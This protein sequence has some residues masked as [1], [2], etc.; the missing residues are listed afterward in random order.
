MRNLTQTAA[1]L[2][3]GLMAG[4]SGAH[5]SSPSGGDLPDAS[6][7]TGN[8]WNRDGGTGTG[9]AT[10]T[11][12]GSGTGTG[13]AD[14]G[15]TAKK[16]FLADCAA[17][18]ECESK[19]CLASKRCSK[20]CADA[21]EC[22]NGGWVCTPRGQ[23]DRVCLCAP[24]SVEDTCDGRDND[25]D[26]EVD[27]GASCEG[28]AVC[29]AGS[30]SCPAANTC[31]TDCADLTKDPVHCGTCTTVCGMNEACENGACKCNGKVCDG[32]CTETAF[33]SS[34]CG[35]CAT[36]CAA[37]QECINSACV[38]VDYDWASW[39]PAAGPN[40]T[41][42]P[43]GGVVD[44]ITRLVWAVQS[45][46]ELQPDQP[47]L[48]WA[49]AAA[50]CA[51][52]DEA[53]QRADAD[54]GTVASGRWRLPTRIELVS[55]LETWRPP[56]MLSATDFPNAIQGPYWTATPAASDATRAWTVN[57]DDGVVNFYPKAA[58]ALVR[59]VK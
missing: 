35:D 16:A 17:D 56:P 23:D 51:S 41:S 20:D 10:G 14:G 26:G 12:T 49:D 4:L 21:A 3:I 28:A 18:D 11:S 42:A 9:S 52:L 53:G 13:E 58:Q 22:P 19:L 25:C 43:G 34:A 37:F 1:V 31:G 6:T 32:K 40:F 30:C 36:P 7:G 46:Y 45:S 5:C 44:T 38:A 59:C 47:L 57:F 29:Q 39:Q 50:L 27:E 24:T 55:I 54:A 15:T 8:N 33:D 2:A 48:S